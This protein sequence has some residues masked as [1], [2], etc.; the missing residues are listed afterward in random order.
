MNSLKE[1]LGSFDKKKFLDLNSEMSFSEYIDLCLKTP[2]LARTSWQMIHDMILEKGF[3]EF[4]EYRKSYKHYNFFDDPDCPILGIEETKDSIVKFVKGA[5]GFYGT[6]KRILLLHGPVGSAKSTICR[7]LKRSLEK[8]SQTDNGAWYSYKWVNLPT[9]VDGIY[10]SPEIECPLHE[11]PL[12]LLP[13]DVRKA[14]LDKMN[15]VHAENC[16]NSN[17][18]YDLRCEGDLNPLCRFFL[19]E[20]LRRNNGDLETVLTNHI[21]VVRKVYSEV[22]RVGIATFQPK[23]EKNQDS[24]ELTGDIDFQKISI[25]GTDS[26]PR[27]FAFR[28]EFCRGNRGLI[29]FIEGLKLDQAFLY[30]LLGATQEQSIK[31]KNFSQITIDEAILMHSNNPEFERLKGNQYMEAFRD[32]TV[33]INVPYTLKLSEEIKILEKDYGQGKVKQHVAP[34]TLEIA[35]LWAILTRLEDD[36]D[37]NINLIEK[38]ELY[39][40]KLLEGWT[41]ETVKEMKDKYPNEGMTFGVSVRYVQDKLANVL[42]NNHEYVNPFMIA[43]ELK[44]G[45]LESALI[46]SKEQINRYVG[47][48]DLALKKLGDILKAEVQEAMVG[49]EN[50][51]IR[52]CSNYIDNVMAY[53]NGVK[54]RNQITGRDEPPNERLM[55]SIEEKVGIPDNQSPDF[56]QMVRGFI[57]DLAHKNKSF[58]W[59]SN[60]KLKKA[61]ELKLFEDVKDTIK[62]SAL[63]GEGATVVD[64]DIQ[65]KIDALK[66]RLIKQYGYNEKSAHDVLEFVGSIFARGDVAKD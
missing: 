50:A 14:I 17:E 20:L 63:S 57:G 32:R 55:R 45:L 61:I 24:T 10:T 29:E 43:N 64:K 6:E 35:A 28:G 52:L 16:N 56:R 33:K 1:I 40:G 8:Y 21:R 18:R 5:A 2:R 15:E 31:P 27:A 46:V 58:K 60:P 19:N 25:F 66:Y 13:T 23:D 62:L 4:E 41:E 26:D 48:V 34:H 11:N 47:C 9:G 42:S 59:D 7:L 37:G 30:D 3:Y 53:V 65:E 49:D 22:D 51:A 39:D 44:D 54:V 12:K 38:A 36:K